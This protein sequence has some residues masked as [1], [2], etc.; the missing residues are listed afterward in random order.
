MDETGFR[1]FLEAQEFDPDQIDQFITLIKRFDSFQEEQKGTIS[2]QVTTFSKKLVEDGKNDFLN[3]VALARYA[4][5]LHDN[6]FYISVVELVDGAE[7]M[8]NLYKK[9]GELHGEEV[10]D[11]IFADIEI[12]TI[13]SPVAERPTVTFSV[14]ERIEEQFDPVTTKDILSSCLRNLEDEWYL[15]EREKYQSCET[16]DEYLEQKGQAFIEQ[17]EGIQAKGGLFFTQEISDDVLEFVRNTP[18]ILSGVRDGHILYEVKIPYMTKQF[19]EETDERMKRY[20][21]CHCPWIRESILDDDTHISPTF[22][23]CS[24]GFHK[25]PYEV[26]FEQPLQADIVETVLAGDRWCKFA[27]H[28][29]EDVKLA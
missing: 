10:R 16:F 11:T 29:P 5:F 6:E 7:A 28:L 14:M 23:N 26:I 15:D 19:L 9:L 4:R 3:Y 22:C 18:E 12:P 8:E 2:E 20:Y 21:Y 25:K 1:Q 13:G 24:A 27:I 17:L